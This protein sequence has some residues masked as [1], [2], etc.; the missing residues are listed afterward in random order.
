MRHLIVLLLTVPSLACARLGET[1]EQLVARFGAAATKA[2]EITLTQGK[3]IEFGTKLTFRQGDWSIECAITDGRSSREVYHKQ[4]E[5]TEDQFATV[6]NSNSQGGKWT[7]TSKAMVKKV[8]REWRRDDGATA[9]WQMGTGMVVTQPA[10]L[11][12]KEKAEAK[13]KADARRVPKI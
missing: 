8:A 13:A 5:W 10:Y 9:V 7:D 6:L 3:I 11:R 2:K 1:E 12:A 4:G